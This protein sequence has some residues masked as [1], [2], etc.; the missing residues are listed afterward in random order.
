MDTL[1]MIHDKEYSLSKNLG[2]SLNMLLQPLTIKRRKKGKW[3]PW[4]GR[5]F[6]LQSY[7]IILNTQPNVIFITY[8]KVQNNI[9]VFSNNKNHTKKQKCIAYS[10]KQNKWRNCPWGLKTFLNILK[11][12]MENIQKELK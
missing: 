9:P 10:R 12:L 6:Y 7:I 4:G 2:K 5:E 1:V 3:K 11:E 8:S